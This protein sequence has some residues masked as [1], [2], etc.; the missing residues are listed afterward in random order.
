V[1]A[2]RCIG[3]SASI[4]RKKMKIKFKLL[5]RAPGRIRV[6]VRVRVEVGYILNILNILNNLNNPS[7]IKA[8]PYPLSNLKKEPI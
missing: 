4:Y 5:I 1:S 6:R 7:I 2:Y 8:C 3:L